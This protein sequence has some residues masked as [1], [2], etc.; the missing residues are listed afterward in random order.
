MNAGADGY[1]VSTSAELIDVDFVCA[2][3][4]GSYW[5]RNRAR[6]VIEESLRSSLCFG[7]YERAGRRQVGFA[8]VVTD[9]IT[10]SW[11]CDVIVA[12]GERGKGLGKMLMASVMSHPR[13]RGTV[14][15]LGTRDAHGLYEKFG[16]ARQEMMRR[17]PPQPPS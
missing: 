11:L 8:R 2:A 12:E 9:G 15:L 5:A 3:L 7:V 14:F 13:I 1:I 10:F 6:D 16:F 4:A 17:L